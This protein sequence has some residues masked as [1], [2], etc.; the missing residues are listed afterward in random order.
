MKEE[1]TE[2]LYLAGIIDGEGT[3]GI[4]KLSKRLYQIRLSVGNTSEGLIDYLQDNYGGNK[5]G[6]Y[7]QKGEK[8]K[9]KFQWDCNGNKAIELIK[10]IE[11]YLIIKQPQAELVLK[12]WE[13]TFKWDY[14]GRETPRYALDKR[15]NLYQQMK[16]LNKKG[17]QEEDS[18]EI[19]VV[20]SK[21]VIIL[22][23]DEV[24]REPII[25]IVDTIKEEDRYNT[26]SNKSNLPYLAAIIDGEGSIGIYQHFQRWFEIRLYVENTSEELIDYL[27]D[28]YGGNKRGPRKHKKENHKDSFLWEC[29]NREAI[30]LIKQIKQYLVIKQERAEVAIQ[31]WKDTFRI[32]YSNISYPKYA[33][34]KRER[35]YQLMRKLNMKGKQQEG[36][37][38]DNEE[39]IDITLKINKN[40][41]RKWL[42]ESE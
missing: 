32:D 9:D 29:S 13:D 15:K 25:E 2:M 37:V 22:E 12:S 4:S 41:L 30:K 18:G 42:E 14:T 31:A 39:E 19:L 35:Y 38:E 8:R 11:P 23:E 10:Q 26:K 27:Q 21:Y 5:F 24:E 40:T 36:D 16:K 33:I 34:D 1:D 17:K 6:P 3:I 20:K 28:I 7:K